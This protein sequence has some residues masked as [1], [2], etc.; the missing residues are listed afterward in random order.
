MEIFKIKTPD[1]FEYRMNHFPQSVKNG[2]LE[3]WT[4]GEGYK[5]TK[6]F[7]IIEVNLP[8]RRDFVSWLQ[9][10]KICLD[11]GIEVANEYAEQKTAG[12]VSRLFTRSRLGLYGK[13]KYYLEK[14]EDADLFFENFIRPDYWLSLGGIWSLDVF[15][16]DSML[17]KYDSNYDKD[18][19]LYC[20]NPC[21]M[22]EYMLKK[23]SE[24]HVKVIELMI[25][26]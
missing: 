26:E 20:G 6:R 25:A 13:A 4:Q 1:G 3:Y 24:N 9:I 22:K 7:E 11:F 16:L 8:D 19:A 12:I 2:K 14:I 18:N 17:A 5:K 10:C 15:Y 21:S 23:F